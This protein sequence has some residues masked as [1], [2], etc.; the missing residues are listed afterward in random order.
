MNILDFTSDVSIEIKIIKQLEIIRKI[1]RRENYTRDYFI[2]QIL[3]PDTS[4]LGSFQSIRFMDVYQYNMLEIFK[5]VKEFAKGNIVVITEWTIPWEQD[6]YYSE[7]IK[8][9]HAESIPAYPYPQVR[10]YWMPKK[11]PYKVYYYDIHL[12][13]YKIDSVLIDFLEEF[14]GFDSYSGYIVDAHKIDV[15]KK[16]LLQDDNNMS[17]EKEF[18]DSV[19]GFFSGVHE[20]DTLAIISK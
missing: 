7:F 8:N 16:F 10:E 4:L 20:C 17:M 15:F 14:R 19:I 2:K 1:A 9:M 12:D 6:S 5:I 13:M 18:R 11:Q 3:T